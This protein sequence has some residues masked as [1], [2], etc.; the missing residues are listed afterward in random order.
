MMFVGLVG[1]V[2]AMQLIAPAATRT[3]RPAA[4]YAPASTMAERIK[5]SKRNNPLEVDSLVFPHTDARNIFPGPASRPAGTRATRYPD[6]DRIVWLTVPWAPK[7][8]EYLALRSKIATGGSTDRLIGW[9]RRNRLNACAEYELRLRLRKIWSFRK[10]EYQ[11][12]R[13]VWYPLAI[14]R[15]TEYAFALPVTGE[16]FVIPDRTG[17]HRIKSGAA[18]AHDLIITKGRKGYSGTG[19]RLEDHYAWG[20]PIVAQADGVVTVASDK[21]P[22]MPIGQ[23]G[24]FN[25]ANYVGVYYGAGIEG[26]YGHIQKDSLKVKRGQRVK[27]GQVLA[28]VGNS[29]ASGTPHLHFTMTDRSSFS[30]RGL[31]AY[32]VRRGTRWLKVS[33]KDLPPNQTIRPWDPPAATTRPN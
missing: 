15:Q 14:K 21:S 16:W 3:R 17:H 30:V 22:D 23:S 27:K 7:H 12:Y 10:P 25:N 8:A 9:C 33:A 29:G 2:A 28:L 13:K 11:T 19:K 24:G 32:E 4:P 31:F 6:A 1:F 20:Q 18:F 26:F 5:A